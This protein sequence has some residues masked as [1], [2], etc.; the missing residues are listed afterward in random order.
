[1]THHMWRPTPT[2]T[3]PRPRRPPRCIA[4]C[5]S[6]PRASSGARGSKGGSVGKC[7]GSKW[8]R[9]TVKRPS[10]LS[11]R[12]VP[13]RQCLAT[14][15]RPC[16]TRPSKARS[17]QVHAYHA[18]HGRRDHSTTVCP[19]PRPH[20]HPAHPHAHAGTR[21]HAPSAARLSVPVARACQPLHQANT[22]AAGSKHRPGTAFALA[23][24]R[25]LP[26]AAGTLVT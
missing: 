17:H 15:A 9:P 26:C 19:V 10:V 6:K 12:T 1:M 3:E 13:V 23:P 11:R 22:T 7:R 8:R 25:R 18:R 21:R 5:R 2:R 4:R 16:S 14:H 20:A 24:A